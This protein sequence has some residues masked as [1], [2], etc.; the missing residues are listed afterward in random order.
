MRRLAPTKFVILG[1]LL[2]I[3][4]GAVVHAEEVPAG[5]AIDIE[6]K[7]A[8][9]AEIQ[10]KRD[11]KLYPLREHELL[12]A[13]DELVFPPGSESSVKVLVDANRQVTLN[14]QHTK[15]PPANWSGL[16]GLLPRFA[17]AYRWLYSR[18]TSDNEGPRNAV[19]RELSAELP[20]S[21]LPG[22][23]GNLVISNDAD[24]PLWI[25]WTEGEAPFTV[26]VSA[27]GKLISQAEICGDDPPPEDCLREALITNLPAGT[28]AL[29]VKVTAAD[30]QQCTKTLS[31][32]F[33][34]KA[35]QDEPLGDLGAFLAAVQ[36]LDQ[37]DGAY[38]L[39]SA[40]ILASI[41]ERYPAAQKLLDRMR[42]GEVP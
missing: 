21:V 16:Q 36:L 2:S 7:D 34:A 33:I 24:P 17:S 35:P 11:G 20:P 12:Y 28:D 23:R 3:L 38:A 13:N 5:V 30:R 18:G 37:D 25:G 39:E 26:T 9:A 8:G 41:R 42:D 10:F 22:L 27:Q 1:I 4:P 19:S 15:L 14:A 32:Q 31:R 29:E 40:R 6:P